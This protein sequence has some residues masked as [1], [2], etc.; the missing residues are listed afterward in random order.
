MKTDKSWSADFCSPV[1]S[2]ND[3]GSLIVK[4]LCKTLSPTTINIVDEIKNT[5]INN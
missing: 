1:E 5:F 3:D 2:K 4:C